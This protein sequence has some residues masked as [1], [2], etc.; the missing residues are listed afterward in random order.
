MSEL[1]V[2][3]TA[4]LELAGLTAV[5]ADVAGAAGAVFVAGAVDVAV[6]AGFAVVVGVGAE[7]LSVALESAAAFLLLRDFFAVVA[8]VSLL[9]AVLSPAADL[10]LA[11][12]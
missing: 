3:E 1:E 2:V 11:A 4:D 8:E 5:A 12:A 7:E 10:S 9:A 6:V